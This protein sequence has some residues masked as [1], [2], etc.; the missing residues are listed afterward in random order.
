LV[1]CALHTTGEIVPLGRLDQLLYPF[2]KADLI[3]GRITPAAAQEIIDCLWIKLGDR[4]I[5]NRRHHEDR[6]SFADGP[7]TGFKGPSNFDQ[8]ALLNQWMQQITVGGFVADEAAEPTDGTNDVTY[9]CLEASRRLPLNSPTLAVR[10]HSGTPAELIEAAARCLLAGGAHPV[11]LNDDILVSSLIR[12]GPNVALKSARNY[13]CDGCFETMLAGETEFSFGFVPAPEVLERALNRGAMI[14]GAGSTHLR[15]LKGSWRTPPPEEIVSFEELW[16]VL[17]K[18]IELGL[19]RFLYN[20]LNLYGEKEGVCPSPLLSALIYGCVETGR[21]LTGGGARYHMFSPLMT[22]ISTA[23]DSLYAIRAMV[24]ASE[25]VCTLDE[26]VSCLRSNWGR[27]PLVHGLYVSP[28]RCAT[29]REVALRCPKY[30]Q[31]VPEVDAL[32]WR[33]ME[34]FGSAVERVRRDPVHAEAFP[35]LRKRYDEPGWPFDLMLPPGVG[36][37]EQ[38][39]G[40]GEGLGASADGRLR[41]QPIA[42]DMSP[43]PIP[44]DLPAATDS[45][46]GPALRHQRCVPLQA[47]LRSYDNRTAVGVFGDGAPFDVNIREDFPHEELVDALRVFANGRAGSVITFTVC[48]PETFAAALRDPDGYDLLRVRM[49]GWSEFFIALF[50]EHQ[51]QHMRRPLFL[52]AQGDRA[53]AEVR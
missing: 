35:R 34:E 33:L 7:M 24:F 16:A 52:A 25:P 5:L 48:N 42:S 32:A 41:G 26:L 11:L 31:G 1:H 4:A 28:E 49:G 44:Q 10:V 14:G 20:I 50:P 51:K 53:I 39:V 3:A 38:Y 37:F 17:A 27:E 29:L 23:V 6:F 45:G 2:Y 8:G 22:G 40:G 18:H 15:G 13:A 43:A 47:A 12:S 19:H 36:T 30:G 21:D 9:F 46:L